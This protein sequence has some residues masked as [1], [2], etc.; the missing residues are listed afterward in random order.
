ML[1]AN[2]SCQAAPKTKGNYDV[3]G[4]VL[5]RKINFR[6]QVSLSVNGG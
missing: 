2:D 6:N 4:E 5:G 3:L 1:Q